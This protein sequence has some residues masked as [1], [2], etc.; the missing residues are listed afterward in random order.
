VPERLN[1]AN[2]K[3]ESENGHAPKFNNLKGD[4]MKFS[5]TIAVA[6]ILI[7]ALLAGDASA[8]K[9]NVTPA[10]MYFN[11]TYEV[12]ALPTDGGTIAL[13]L[14]GMKTVHAAWL[15]FVKFTGGSP[16]QDSQVIPLM[17]GVTVKWSGGKESCVYEL[18]LVSSPAAITITRPSGMCALKPPGNAVFRILA[19]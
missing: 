8:Q 2:F 10:Q 6:T 5:S 1:V 4:N 16:A 14:T 19:M 12:P 18:R 13:N 7:G 9:S 17:E 15:T 11:D 3:T